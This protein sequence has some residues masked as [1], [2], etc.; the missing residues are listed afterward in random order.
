[1]DI[2]QSW[3]KAQLSEKVGAYT[4]LTVPQILNS[5]QLLP[6]L[7]KE[8]LLQEI[9]HNTHFT[10]SEQS[11][12][13]DELWKGIKVEPPSF[14]DEAGAWL[15]SV[16]DEIREPLK[17][18]LAQLKLNKHIDTSYS[19]HVEP[20]FL[21]RRAD[22]ERVVY[23]LIRVDSQ[24]IAEE[25]YLRL[26]EEEDEFCDLASEYSLGDEKY[27]NG[28]LGPMAI[29]QPP[30]IIRNVIKKLKV[31]E[32]H[33]PFRADKFFILLK[34]VHR[35]SA[36]LD[37]ATRNRLMMELFERDIQQEVGKKVQD[38][39]DQSIAAKQFD[40]VGEIKESHLLQSSQDPVT[41]DNVS[42]N[43][44]TRGDTFVSS[45][46]QG[47]ILK[48]DPE[49]ANAKSEIA[50][51]STS[52]GSELI[53]PSIAVTKNPDEPINDVSHQNK[54]TLG[55]AETVNDSTQSSPTESPLSTHADLDDNPRVISSPSINHAPEIIPNSSPKIENREKQQ[56]D[57]SS[58]LS[59]SNSKERIGEV[60]D[61]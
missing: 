34:L 3:F 57:Q 20:Y 35:I 33:P 23:G 15:N 55:A 43:G 13:I 51:S 48:I 21:Q 44:D 38:T 14:L 42:P 28:L 45:A 32:V 56:L 26:L 46:Q 2:E 9:I 11:K 22:L 5:V 61:D 47:S 12:V 31:G 50:D 59:P 24:G 17:Q 37:D 40:V 16:P 60:R 1:M 39:V 41:S 7:T 8:L 25:F 18:R 27:T 53:N 19:P 30:E 52:I 29:T 58:P 6:K 54:K 36:S 10:E 49:F 4:D